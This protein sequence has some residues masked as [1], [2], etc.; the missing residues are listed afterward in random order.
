MG[1]ERDGQI[2]VC[3]FT[4]L[5]LWS[6]EGERGGEK[7]RRRGRE[8]LKDRQSDGY[9]VCCCLPPGLGSWVCD[10]GLCQWQEISYLSPVA[11]QGA[12][13]GARSRN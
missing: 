1:R 9:D 4:S 3:W 8:R 7:E 10:L 11:S 6:W 12:G 13:I 2:T 5:V